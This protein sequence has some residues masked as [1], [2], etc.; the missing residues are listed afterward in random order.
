MNAREYMH[1]NVSTA[2]PMELVL[3]LYD[4]AI[5]SLEKAEAAFAVTDPSGI[6][7][8]G[9]H[10]LHAQDVITELAISLDMDKGGEIARNLQRL[11]D[12]M[13]NHLSMANLKKD[14][15]AVKAVRNMMVELKTAWSEVAKKEPLSDPFR[16][17]TPSKSMIHVAG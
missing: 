3:M 2:S 12:F 7:I 15:N 9:G 16:A 1:T 14:I 8:I 10:L 11:Y 17:A 13:I 4:E 5:K 6:E